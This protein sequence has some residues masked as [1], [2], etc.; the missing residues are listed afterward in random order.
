MS[1]RRVAA[2]GCVLWM[3]STATSV[4]AQSENE[5]TAEQA[6]AAQKSDKIMA[7]ANAHKGLLA[8][9]LVLRQ[10]YASDNSRA[11]RMIF[12]Q[13]VSW[14]QSF[15]GDYPLA[16]KSFSIAQP[17]QPDDHPSPLTTGI[18]TAR[19]A[20]EAIPELARHY[21]I[22]LFNEAHNVALTRSLTVQLLSRLREEGFDYFAAETLVQSDTALA[23]R[24]YPTDDSGFYTEEPVYAEMVRTALKL[25]FKVVAYEATSSALS[26]DAREAEQARHIYEQVFAHDPKARLIVNAGYDHIVTSGPY[27]GGKSMAEYLSALAKE[28]MLSVEQT[29]LYPRPSSNDDHP[30]YTTVMQKLHPDEPIVFV[31][32]KGKPWS[33]RP[34]YDIS[35]FF[36][37]IKLEHGRPG[38]LSLGG[39]RRPYP[40]TADNCRAH[41]PCLVEARYDNEGA[42]AIPADRMLLEQV[43]LGLSD[44]HI[45]VYSSNQGVPSSDLYL[46]PGKYQVSFETDNDRVIHREDIVVPEASH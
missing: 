19:P 31:D 14:Y 36:P 44:T 20:V 9:Y 8:Q 23:S 4:C 2:I 38:W 39:L 33:L 26:G 40:V 27:L 11:F 34:G 46:R 17:A 28:P 18:Y 10:A 41:Y 45:A 3:A 1:A 32:A 37:P 12:G 21:R 5:W 6:A 35:V 43:P 25:G 16:V 13:Y 42:D 29:M 7:Q 15:L 30:Y 22:V 24:G